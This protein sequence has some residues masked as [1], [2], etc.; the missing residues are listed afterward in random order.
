[1][2]SVNDPDPI[3]PAHEFEPLYVPV[4]EDEE[5][6]ASPET[7]AVHAPN[8]LSNPP[9]GTAIENRIEEPDRVPETDPRPLMP[10]AVSV[11]V[12]VPENDE[13]AWVSCHDIAPAPD[14]SVAEPVHV[15]LTDVEGADGCV[16]VGVLEPPLPPPQLVNTRASTAI[17]GRRV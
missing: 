11:I 14:E 17:T 2:F 6:W 4:S 8:G 10:V 15:P 7:L 9:A 16:G 13:S 1:L 3:E 5:A 12:T